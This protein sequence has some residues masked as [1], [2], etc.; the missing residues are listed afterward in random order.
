MSLISDVL[1]DGV[2]Y[3]GSAFGVVVETGEQVFLNKRIVE[4][5]GLAQD[6][7]VRATLIPNYEDK[8]ATIPW[9]AI[10]VEFPGEE[11]E[12]RE[13]VNKVQQVYDLI[14]EHGPLRTSVIAQSLGMETADAATLCLGLFAEKKIALAEIYAEPGQKR[15]SIRVWGTSINDF[16]FDVED[17]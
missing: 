11:G 4:K 12:E 2:S 8:K 3:A 15:S 14:S 7:V 9:R 6:Q 10:H 17:E 13:P 16:D 1:I 5:T